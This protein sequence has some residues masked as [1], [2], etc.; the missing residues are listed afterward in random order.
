MIF[1]VMANASPFCLA[2]LHA[3]SKKK[4]ATRVLQQ[5]DVKYTKYASLREPSTSHELI[6]PESR[7]GTMLKRLMAS[8]IKR[9]DA[10]VYLR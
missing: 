2:L 1:H 9:T 3:R 6:N 4:L 8:H 10:R 5:I 7:A